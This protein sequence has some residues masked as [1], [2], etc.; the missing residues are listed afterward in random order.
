MPSFFCSARYEL[1]TF[2]M[3]AERLSNIQRAPVSNS[4][5]GCLQAISDMLQE[6]GIAYSKISKEICKICVDN[7]RELHERRQFNS[8]P[9]GSWRI[10]P[11]KC[12]PTSWRVYYSCNS[13]TI[14][15]QIVWFMPVKGSSICIH[16]LRVEKK[17]NY[18]QIFG[19]GSQTVREWFISSLL[20]Q[21]SLYAAH[22]RA[23]ESVLCSEQEEKLHKIKTDH[24]NH[25]DFRAIL[26]AYSSNYRALEPVIK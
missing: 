17:F 19:T 26:F 18:Y 25:T 5:G 20:E 7:F 1:H 4:F 15:D 11:V 14:Y 6:K 23:L 10:W 21:V 24:A 12:A 3:S 2:L 16:Q 22:T 13:F 8:N 9:S